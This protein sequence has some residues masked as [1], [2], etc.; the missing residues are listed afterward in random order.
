MRSTTVASAGVYVFTCL[1]QAGLVGEIA[2]DDGAR[3]VEAA[4]LSVG[5]LALHCWHLR[6]GLCGRRPPHGLATLV[7]LTGV[8]AVGQ[9]VIGDAWTW[10]FALAAISAVLVLPGARGLAALLA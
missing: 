5:V 4:M 1:L 10:T 8:I 6:F 2:L 7:A 9:V 3:A